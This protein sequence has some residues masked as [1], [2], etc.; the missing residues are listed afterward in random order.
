M[1]KGVP[2]IQLA[3]QIL[4]YRDSGQGEVLLLL[5]ANPGDSRDFE[6]MVEVLS[7]H[8]RLIAPD[9]PAYGLSPAVKNIAS[10]NCDYL[11]SLIQQFIQV[12]SLPSVIILGNS[13][14]GNVALRVAAR[15]PDCVKGLVLVSPGGFTPH[16][17]FSRQF[18]RLQSSRFAIPASIFARFYL[19]IRTGQTKAMIARAK[20]LSNKPEALQSSRQLW[21]SFAAEENDVRAL[22]AN[23]R[24]P[25]LFIFGTY[26]PIILT[27]KDGKE[28]KKYCPS[29][30]HIELPCGHAAF[31]ECP[32]VFLSCVETFLQLPSLQKLVQ[33]D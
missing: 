24:L 25:M 31:A 11:A 13:V 5:H 16:N 12:L 1:Y 21:R 8:Y 3:E 18:C 7:G 10:F 20:A 9:W 29:A 15:M 30:W 26:D 33:Q 22:A 32:D 4:N 23:L 2:R 6:G 28:A 14:G 19:R 27:R 17:F